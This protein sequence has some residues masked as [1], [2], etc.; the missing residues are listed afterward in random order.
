MEKD[1]EAGFG[2]RKRIVGGT[3]GEGGIKSVV[4]S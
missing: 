2:R 1:V 3:M 4:E